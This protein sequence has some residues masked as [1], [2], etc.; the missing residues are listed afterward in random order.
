LPRVII[1]SG[2]S[3]TGKT[4]VVESLQEMLL[5]EVW[6]KFS[7]DSIIYSLPGSTLEQC[8]LHNNW[9]GVDGRALYAGSIACLRSL[10]EAGNSVI[11]DVVL[12]SEKQVG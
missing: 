5:P 8:N 11:F 4:S 1:I 7:F 9:S 10:V 6:L 12:S 2:S 3:G